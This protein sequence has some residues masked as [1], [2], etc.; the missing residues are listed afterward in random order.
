MSKI[1]TVIGATGIQGGSVI[2]ALVDSPEYSLRAVTRNTESHAAKELAA[3]G[4]EVVGADINDVGSLREAFAGSQAVFAATNFFEALPTLGIEKSMEMETRLGRNIA[5]A[6]AATESLEHYVWST[7]PNSRK[8]TGGKVVVPYYESKNR[9]DDHIKAQHPQLLRKTTFL[10]LGWYASNM[11]YPWYRPSEVHTAGDDRLYV[12]LLSVSTSVKIPVLGDEKVNP[13]LFVRT[14]LDRPDL[15]LPAKVVA[16]MDEQLALSEIARV[17]GAAQGIN[18][19]SVQ[20]TKAD[21][22]K[23]WPAWGELMDVSH[24]YMEVMDG[25]GFTSV[26][27]DVLSKEDLGVKGLIGTAQ[28]FVKSK[29]GCL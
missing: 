20:I 4:V 29:T 9:V 10:W 17:Y 8:N 16:G 12:Q 22:E 6:A 2:R 14:I 28:A 19:R 24:S 5:D 25:K 7:L 18:V 27:E 13:G 11:D 23:L 3:R 21:Y 15:T 26:D 1:V